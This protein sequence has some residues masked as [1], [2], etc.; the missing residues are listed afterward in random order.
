M[1]RSGL[2]SERV[3]ALLIL[4]ILLFSPP[5]ILIFD[6]TAMIAGIPVLFLYLFVAWAALIA[7]MVLIIE[8]AEDV[9]DDSN[10]KTKSKDSSASVA[11]PGE[12]EH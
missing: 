9:R 10:L 5:F 11:G 8:R 7:L 1:S 3:V 12:T 4:G 6:K 2:A